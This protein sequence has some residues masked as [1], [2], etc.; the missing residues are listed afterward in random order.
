MHFSKSI[1]N[2]PNR[3]ENEYVLTELSTAHSTTKNVN[4]SQANCRPYN[5][6]SILNGNFI[7]PRQAGANPHYSRMN[8]Q[9]TEKETYS[10]VLSGRVCM[11]ISVIEKV[12][13][14]Q[15]YYIL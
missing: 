9:F 6:C 1:A 11:L 3:I 5:N 14:F 4:R 7:P 13:P 2:E 15:R 8:E 10:Q 12:S